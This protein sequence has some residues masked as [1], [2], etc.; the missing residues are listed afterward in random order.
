MEKGRLVEFK[1]KGEPVLAIADRP[2][3]KKNWILIDI[4]GH[5]HTIHPRQVIYEIP[6]ASCESYQEIAG[7]VE[8]ADGYIDPENLEVAW[9]LLIEIE[10]SATPESLAQILFSDTSAPLCYAAHQMLSADRLYFKQKGDRYEPRSA[11]QVEELK[12][13]IEREAAKEVEWE[14]FLT[15]TKAILAGDVIDIE[16]SDRPRQRLR[17][18]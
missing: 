17:P 11:S 10:E 8:E 1:L 7:F 13:K 12:L 5:A 18:R 16:K 3:G 2:E 9:E 6:Q 15:R 4:R 14:G